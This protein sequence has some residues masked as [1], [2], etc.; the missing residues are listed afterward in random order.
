MQIL[1]TISWH[2]TGISQI[3]FLFLVDIT[4]LKRA[5]HFVFFR[6]DVLK[7]EHV[8]SLLSKFPRVGGG[9][10]R[11]TEP[12]KLYPWFH[13][14]VMLNHALEAGG[15][16]TRKQKLGSAMLSIRVKR[17]IHKPSALPSFLVST[18]WAENK[19]YEYQWY[20]VSVFGLVLGCIE[21]K[22]DPACTEGSRPLGFHDW[23]C[24]ARRRPTSCALGAGG[25][26]RSCGLRFL[27]LRI[28]SGIQK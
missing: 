26:R 20:P 22:F 9:G 12:N 1:F 14:W 8:A 7:G 11:W 2:L 6:R 3:S 13:P 21:A 27:L 28:W 19:G 23:A 17:V 10:G 25:L 18:R 16:W 24:Y 4:A 5:T 15:P